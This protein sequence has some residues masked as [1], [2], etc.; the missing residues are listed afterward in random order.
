MQ[1]NIALPK[2]SSIIY[3]TMSKLEKLIT[4]IKN[5]PKGVRFTDACKIAELL[6]FHHKGGQGSHRVFGREDE[7]KLLNFQNRD[8][9]IPSYQ[10][11]QLIEM[12][13]KYEHRK[14]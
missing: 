8:G 6:G 7:T 10:A 9:L 13:D 12:I 4:A 11:R 5:N 1:K 3:N 14:I 2:L